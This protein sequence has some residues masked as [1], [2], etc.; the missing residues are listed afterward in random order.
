MNAK[1]FLAT[2]FLGLGLLSQGTATTLAQE[3]ALE[4]SGLRSAVGAALFDQLNTSQSD[5]IGPHFKAGESVLLDQTYNGD[6]YAAGGMLRM[7]GTVNGD[8]MVAG[9]T[10]SIAGEVSDDLRVAGGTVI[11]DGKVGKNIT[12]IGGTVTFTPESSVGGSVLIAGG[13]IVID[14]KINGNVYGGSGAATLSGVFGRNVAMDVGTLT[15][16]EQA[17]ISGDLRATVEKS[18][19][20]N[21]RAQIEGSRDI[22]VREPQ[23]RQAQPVEGVKAAVG[24]GIFAQFVLGSLMAIVAGVVLLYL[25]PQFWEATATTIEKAP[26]STLGWGLTFV[27]LLPIIGILLILTVV[28][29]PLAILLLFIWLSSMIV[30]GWLSAYTLG[31]LIAQKSELEWLKSRYLQLIVGIVTMNSIG[32]IPV[33]GWLVSVV[34]FFVGMG[35]V[36]TWLRH[37][38]TFTEHAKL[39]PVGQ[40]VKRG[41]PLRRRDK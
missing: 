1:I 36:F 2:F 34:L 33:I 26:V 8:L 5:Q 27:L 23:E 40:P 29:L 9:G 19:N 13:S 25:F 15:I 38:V 3:I 18:P 22:A 28:G 21:P 11:I 10:V 7:S 24:A 16:A 32:L 12:V 35:A 4:P 41:R 30:A 17:S 20:V 14:G 39:S 6:V 37:R 31:R